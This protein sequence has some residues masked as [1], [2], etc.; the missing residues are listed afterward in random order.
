[1]TTGSKTG[2]VASRSLSTQATVT[3]PDDFVDIYAAL[4]AEREEEEPVRVAQKRDSLSIKTQMATA[5][6]DPSDTDGPDGQVPYTWHAVTAKVAPADQLQATPAF[7][8]AIRKGALNKVLVT[9][10]AMEVVVG[11]PDMAVEVDRLRKAIDA[12][13]A[14]LADRRVGE[15]LMYILDAIADSFFRGAWQRITPEHLKAMREVCKKARDR[16]ELKPS[17][18]EELVLEMEKVGIDMFPMLSGTEAEM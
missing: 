6:S 11:Q 10:G 18:A 5:V 15:P 12:A 8:R 14:V 2:S 3:Q 9:L 7:E 1:M 4:T 13:D 17:H 16:E